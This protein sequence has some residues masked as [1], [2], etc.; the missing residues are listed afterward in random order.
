VDLADKAFPAAKK[1]LSS[2]SPSSSASAEE[3]KSTSA[4]L[5]N[6]KGSGILVSGIDNIL[7]T[8]GR[9]CN[10]LPGDGIVGFVTRGRG[11]SIHRSTCARALDLDPVRRIDVSWTDLDQQAKPLHS[12]FLRII[13]HDRQGVLADITMAIAS[14]GANIQKASVKVS[15]DLMGILD[16]EVNIKSLD[17]L[18]KVISKLE[19][20][21]NVVLVE[22][23]EIDPSRLA[24]NNSRK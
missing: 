7:V 23:R 15:S 8:I 4:P 1:S 14:C 20:I 3:H 12:A 19:S 9:C 18:N 17:H 5:A 24:Q 2:T 6:K 10:P 11:V 16:F 21:A 13:T 22:R